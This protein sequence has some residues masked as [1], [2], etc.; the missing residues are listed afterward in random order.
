MTIY[1]FF[2]SLFRITPY[3]SMIAC[4]HGRISS[5]CF[6]RSR[7]VLLPASCCCCVQRRR[8]PCYSREIHVTERIYL[9]TLTKIQDTPASEVARIHSSCI[10]SFDL[11]GRYQNKTLN[12]MEIILSLGFA[13]V[14]F[15]VE[16][17]DDRK[18]V[19]VRR[20]I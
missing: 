17:S 4:G 19:C 13:D 3:S 11:I 10:L 5:R 6:S 15:L 2:I 9:V 20:L 16:R 1:F 7:C 18:Y 14:T 12:V 8:K